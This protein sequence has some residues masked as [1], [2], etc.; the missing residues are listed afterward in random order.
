MHTGTSEA[1]WSFVL[2][3]TLQELSRFKG[4]VLRV[5]IAAGGCG[6]FQYNFAVE[7]EAPPS[8][9]DVYVNLQ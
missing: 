4:K 9:E 8:D 2:N 5:G 3:E 1:A 7:P 6:G